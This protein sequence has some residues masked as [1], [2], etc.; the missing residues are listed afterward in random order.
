MSH[1]TGDLARRTALLMLTGIG[2]LWAA[3]APHAQE[4]HQGMSHAAM[5]HAGMAH[6]PV[7]DEHSAHRVAAASGR[8]AA[9]NA[10]YAIPDVMLLDSDGTAV[11]LRTVL[12]TERPIALNFIFTTCT[13][14][15][16]IM[17]ATF[18]QM[19][20]ELGPAAADVELVSISIDPE[21]DRPR[22]LKAYTEQFGAG[23]GW[24]FL[25]GDSLDIERVLR[26][27]DVYAG[28]KMNHR[29]VTL[30]RRPGAEEWTRIDG[31]ASGA[32]LAREVTA[33]LLD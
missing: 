7:A 19:Q 27:F 4:H 14:I 6:E 11:P 20:H 13:T 12:D 29:P 10:A 15:C 23:P 2:A 8:Y 9:R 22:V 26:S 24:T 1:Y 32:D 25:T 21:Y 17:T 5:G 33:R 30:L 28:S 16:P 31:L 18:V 3:R